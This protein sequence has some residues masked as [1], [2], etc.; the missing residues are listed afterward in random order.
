MAEPDLKVIVQRM[1]DA[2]ESEDNI[3]SVIQSAKQP[4]SDEPAFM[5]KNVGEFLSRMGAAAVDMP[6]GAFKNMGRMVQSVP[7]PSRFGM[8]DA[9][10]MADTVYGLPSGAS[11]QAMQSTNDS[12][13]VGSV[14]G[15]LA[16][17]VATA[18]AEAGGPILNRSQGYISNPTVAERLVGPAKNAAMMGTD[19]AKAIRAELAVAKGTPAEKIARA[20]VKWGSRAVDAAIAGTALAGAYNL[21]K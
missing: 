17:A 20:S 19:V 12:Q 9:A 8:T 6:I 21:M 10:K 18:G 15:D 11:S 16:L 4:S 1:I 2:G 13:R 3:A 14:L 7:I 5:P